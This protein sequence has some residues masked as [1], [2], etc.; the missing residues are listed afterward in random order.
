MALRI[1]VHPGRDQETL[2]RRSTNLGIDPGDFSGVPRV[3]FLN[4]DGDVVHCD[5][6]NGTC[7][8][9]LFTLRNEIFQLPMPL[10]V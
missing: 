8:L 4:L 5:S 3:L 2:V 6:L 7:T 1:G 9:C 10:E